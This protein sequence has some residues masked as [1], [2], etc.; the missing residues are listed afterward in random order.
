M[1]ERKSDAVNS[2]G[3]VGKRGAD[4]G[5][6]NIE[7][8]QDTED[9]EQ[10]KRADIANS[11]KRSTG[12]PRGRP[13]RNASGSL[14]LLRKKIGQRSNAKARKAKVQ[15][16]RRAQSGGEENRKEALK[17]T[18]RSGGRPK[19]PDSDSDVDPEERK[20]GG[21]KRRGR[22]STNLVV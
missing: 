2:E 7:E 16:V 19:Q 6:G 10:N 8:E 14:A 20:D 9:E 17:N 12:R 15:R 3:N 18:A 13:K 22:S 1:N 11:K 21:S 5:Q 4:S